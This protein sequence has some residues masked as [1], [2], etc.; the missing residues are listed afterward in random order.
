MPFVVL[1]YRGTAQLCCKSCTAQLYRRAAAV[2]TCGSFMAPT[3]LLIK[4]LQ[5]GMRPMCMLLCMQEVHCAHSCCDSH[6]FLFLS[7]KLRGAG[8]RVTC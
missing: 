7:L 5:E 2:G 4:L 1:W 6:V 8:D 3:Q